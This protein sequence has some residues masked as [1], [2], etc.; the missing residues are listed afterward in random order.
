MDTL[1]HGLWTNIMYKMIPIT[2][3][4]RKTTLWGIAF[5]VLPDLISFTPF[6]AFYFWQLISGA[7]KFGRPDFE[8]NALTIYAEQSYNYTHSL[9]IWLAM[10]GVVFLIYRKVPWI[11]FGW[12]L[13]IVIDIFTHPTFY[14]TPFLFPIS[15]FKNDYAISWAHPVFM[16]IN[17]TALLFFYICILPRIKRKT[18][19]A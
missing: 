3:N 4:D 14:Q 17:Y 16:I 13:H 2:R 10:F 18:A 1:S 11:L 9:V 7:V 6:F 19:I 8:Q 12:L 5:G 15:G